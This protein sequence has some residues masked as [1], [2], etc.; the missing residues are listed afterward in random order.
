MSDVG[1]SVTD[2][3]NYLRSGAGI[4]LEFKAGVTAALD[5]IVTAVLKTCPVP[6]MVSSRDNVPNFKLN[7][8]RV[9]YKP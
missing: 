8:P 2:R 7:H 4:T 9:D 3:D 1:N 6:M 5:D